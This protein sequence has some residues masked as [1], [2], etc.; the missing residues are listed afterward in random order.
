MD[1]IARIV[2]GVEPSKGW[3]VRF[4]FGFH[5]ALMLMAGVSLVGSLF[6]WEEQ[7]GIVANNPISEE[8]E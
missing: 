8:P 6:M 1:T 7:I 3:K 2:S 5:R 4:I